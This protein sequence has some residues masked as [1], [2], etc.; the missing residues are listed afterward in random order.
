M[1]IH[2]LM[3]LVEMEMMKIDVLLSTF[4]YFMDD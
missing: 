2:E 1:F 3:L 4:H